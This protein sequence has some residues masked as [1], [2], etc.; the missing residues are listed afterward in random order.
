MGNYY[1]VVPE[2]TT[3][4]V[5]NPAA[6]GKAVGYSGTA[7]ITRVNTYSYA[8]GWAYSI[9]F[10]GMK[11]F[12]LTLST[13][14]NAIHYVTFRTAGTIHA[15]QLSLNGSNFNT[16]TLLGNEGSWYVYGV[17]ISA[18]QSNGSTTLHIHHQDATTHDLVI[19]FIQVEEKTYATTPCAGH[20]PG[21]TWG[22]EYHN[23]QSTRSSQSRSGG[24]V[25]D[26]ESY[27][28]NVIEVTGAGMPPLIQKEQ[29]QSL[30]DGAIYKGSKVGKR[31]FI[32]SGQVEGTSIPDL[33]SK[34]KDLIDAIKPDLVNSAQPFILRF[35]GANSSNPIDIECVYDSGLEFSKGVDTGYIENTP[36]TLIAYDPYWHDLPYSSV[37]LA[38][39]ASL[40]TTT[41]AI[42]KLSGTW[43]NMDQG[44]DGDIYGLIPAINGTLFVIGAF[45]HAGSAA[46]TV[47]RIAKWD[48][49]AWSALGGTPGCNGAIYAAVEAP[50][51]DIY[52]GGAFTTSGGTTT[53]HVAKYTPSTD[54]WSALGS[55]VTKGV[56]NDVNALAI[57]QN[58]ILYIGGTFANAGGS[59]ATRIVKYNP[60]TNAFTTM[61]TGASSTV[62]AL[63]VGLDNTVYIGGDFATLN[64]VT[65]TRLGKWNGSAFS[66]VG[67]AVAGG[68]AIVYSLL[69][70]SNG[71][72]YVGGDFTTLNSVSCLRIGK[73]NGSVFSPLGG[74]ADNGV[75]YV[76][77]EDPSGNIYIS[78]SFTSVASSTLIQYVGI[79]NGY[80]WMPLE[81]TLPVNTTEGRAVV[82]RDNGD[83]YLGFNGTGTSTTAGQTT[84]NNTG[85][86]SVFPKLTLKRDDGG[87]S[88]TF[89]VLNN[90]TTDDEL[91]FNYPL[92]VGEE[93]IVDFSPNNKTITSNYY[94]KVLRALLRGS[95]FASFKLQPGNNTITLF[96]PSSGAG[97]LTSI[98]EWKN[99]FWSLDGSAL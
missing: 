96:I 8:G 27:G 56:D 21:C 83:F 90:E 25:Y 48:G 67:G 82:V 14:A 44:V 65:C 63:A 80:I 87:V 62:R 17:Q 58:G 59:A 29:E 49:T 22:G 28:F 10:A 36:I 35:T 61:G 39:T 89:L 33:H 92:A 50:N 41:H 79:W 74:G 70:A 68:G 26:L 32:L 52:V 85:T 13:L 19:G 91:R 66:A 34:R 9:Q 38:E 88:S 86:A 23:S 40:A 47:N 84:V 1:I 53:N 11:D 43:S 4:K 54:V 31:I 3:N 46:T 95:D 30:L 18:A 71:T 64:G 75:V 78:G 57:D 6:G 76:I 5:H 94:G 55:G 98:L 69:V 45:T 42:A 60:T 93:L 72:L 73:W 15:I 51:G 7:T 16:P 99:N 97:V 12:D 24:R 37:E 77:Y 2:S 20:L 81:V